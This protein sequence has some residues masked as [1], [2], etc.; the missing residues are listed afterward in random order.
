MQ[1]GWERRYVPIKTGRLSY[2]VRPGSG[3]SVVLIPGTYGDSASWNGVVALLP[4]DWRVVVAEMRGCGESGPVAPDGSIEMFSV[5][6]LR[7]VDD[8]G[9]D[10][11][12]VGGHSLGGMTAIQVA[13]TRPGSVRGVVSVEG[14]TDSDVLADAF[15]GDVANTLTPQLAAAAAAER[16]RW[17]AGWLEQ[18]VIAQAQLWRRWS[19]L[20]ILQ[21]T[22]VEVLSVWGDRG[23][24]RPPRTA[25]QL[26][27]R[28]NVRLH[29]IENASHSLL[30]ERPRDLSEVVTSFVTELERH[31]SRGA[32]RNFVNRRDQSF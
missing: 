11:F 32:S 20:R 5:D 13:G 28:E 29:W 18:D 25:L 16:R 12:Y 10:E 23:R 17:L 31:R 22:R 1:A 14:W 27:D 6:V 7:V 2:V 4:T 9:I 21:T 24:R 15:N 26:P 3:P 19:G 30:I 8:L